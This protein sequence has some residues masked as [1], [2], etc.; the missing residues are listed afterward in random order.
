M[1][2]WVIVGTKLD[3]NQL[4]KDLKNAEKRLR[5]YEKEAEKLTSQKA[6]IQIEVDAYGLEKD[7][8]KESTEELL[9]LSQTEEQVKN[10]LSMEDMQLES[11]NQ[12]YSNQLETA[13]KINH[14]IK[15][16]IKNQ[17]LLKEQISQTKEKMNGIHIDF[18][19][20][21][22][23][24]GKVIKKVAKW[25]LAIFGIRSAYM[26]VRSAM[27]TLSQYNEDLAKKLETAKILLAVALEPI[28][29]RIVDAVHILLTY[30]N[31]IA[32]AWF[33]VDLFSKANEMSLKKS[34]K[35]ADQMK[36][37]LTGFDEM[38]TVGGGGSGAQSTIAAPADVPVPSWLQWIMDNKDTVITVLTAIGIALAALKVAELFEKVSSLGK[39]FSTL[40]TFIS[41]NAT[42][43]GGLAA[44]IS[45]VIIFVK[46][47][48]DYLNDPSWENF[49]QMLIGLGLIAAGVFLIFGGFPAIITLII[50]AIVA[51][52]LA[53]YKN[54]DSVMSVL[55][56]VGRWI[57]D[58][59][60]KPVSDF[61]VG[62]WNGIINGVNWAVSGI[63]NIFSSVITFFKNIITTI[64]NLFGTIG[65]KVGNAIG[66]AFKFVINGALTLIENMLNNPIKA[67]NG[68]LSVINAV[69]GINLG[70]LPTFKLP[71]LAVG[72]I[73]N[74][75][76]K[77]VPI[78]GAIGGEAGA[79]GVIPLTDTQAM[80]TLGATIG[81]Y[82]N[83]NLTNIT[84]LDNRQIAR[85]QKKINAQSDFAYNR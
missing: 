70:K 45:G 71:R 72:G 3:S 61:F 5:Q 63:K 23:S 18:E 65:T 56:K 4:E 53:I 14:S 43:L 1:D 42:V 2:G 77:G 55:S 78:G 81:K 83:I 12:K 44:I 46:N 34:A 58:N 17:A 8:I 76:G 22:K 40:I 52:A 36:K 6:K 21:G 62:L 75:P 31:M 16:N 25:G 29:N 64:V 79:E 10:V 57:Y 39:A 49:G 7:Q 60:I 41:N 82:I 15:E 80:E 73:V 24:T 37:S 69:P 32:K 11:L 9:K 35:S 54:W 48:I 13:N 30:I 84:K 20:L 66:T 28:I 38:N 47:I 27:S 59:V 51:L 50:G 74:M 85:E 19:K 68:L 26:T 67:I 33:N